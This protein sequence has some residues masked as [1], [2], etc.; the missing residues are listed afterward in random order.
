MN[1]SILD[2]KLQAAI[3]EIAAVCRPA[4]LVPLPT[5]QGGHQLANAKYLAS[6]GKA[7][8]VEEGEGFGERMKEELS[9]I[10]EIAEYKK[11]IE[12]MWRF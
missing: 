11:R 10:V 1:N 9:K 3:N 12:K 7:V 4:I 8:I 5:S 2:I 6:Q